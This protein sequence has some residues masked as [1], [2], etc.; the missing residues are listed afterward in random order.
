MADP[1][2]SDTKTNDSFKL[3]RA[4]TCNE[5]HYKC[6]NNSSVPFRSTLQCEARL[7]NLNFTNTYTESQ[8]AKF[9]FAK[10]SRYTVCTCTWFKKKNQDRE[11]TNFK[12]FTLIM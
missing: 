10:L 2:G 6:T 9:N 4:C 7:P 5:V 3:N 11:M 8:F 1:D 12:Y